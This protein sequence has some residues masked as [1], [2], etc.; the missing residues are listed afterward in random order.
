MINRKNNYIC[1]LFTTFLFNVSKSIWVN[2]VKY[3]TLI[4]EKLFTLWHRK[5]RHKLTHL[6]E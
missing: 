6:A 1:L 4:F 5:L 3:F 2:K